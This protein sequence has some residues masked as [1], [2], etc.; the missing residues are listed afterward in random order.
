MSRPLADWA[1]LKYRNHGHLAHIVPFGR[2]ATMCGIV[3]DFLDPL[4]GTGTFDEIEHAASL[5]LCGF[6]QQQASPNPP[7][8][9][10]SDPAVAEW[11]DALGDFE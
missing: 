5:P 4:L 9:L 3:D 6:C 2:E 10:G 11:T 8:Q 7:A 1:D